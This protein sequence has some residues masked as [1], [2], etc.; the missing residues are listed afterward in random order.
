MNTIY[1]LE[2]AVI[3]R[4]ADLLP[5]SSS[6]ADQDI[7]PTIGQDVLPA[8]EQV[9]ESLHKFS[10]EAVKETLQS[11]IPG[12]LALGI[13][14][15]VAALIIFIGSRV[16]K[17]VKKFLRKTFQRM[18]LDLGVS[19]FLLSV[20]EVCIYAIAVF[21]AAD[22]FGIPSA[23]IVALL[24]SAGLAIGLSLKDSLANVAGGILILLMRP[25]T[26]NDYIIFE[27]M[28]GTVQN[29]GL[30]YTTL[31]AADNKKI[32]IPNGSISNG[33][34]I[35]VTA[36]EKRRVDI[37]VGIG[38]TSD[39]KKAK[40]ILYRIF[41]S[42]PRVLKEEGITVYVGQLADSAVIIGGRGWTKTDDYWSVRW[43]IIESIKEEFDK[44]GIEI[45]YNQL[46]VNLKRAEK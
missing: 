35:N 33:A 31:A 12:L 14:L 19:K 10:P 36:Q 26:V 42:E 15:A 27:D 34:V 28:E 22:N 11:W 32:T 9:K 29:I 16:A 30:V 40:E 5:A 45:P 4:T 39:M 43:G 38:Y 41:E 3:R 17:G 24:G 18:E 25:F 8:A 1:K 37:E 6:G 20:A 13:R 44:A 46:D 7:F 21:I 23:S 2:T